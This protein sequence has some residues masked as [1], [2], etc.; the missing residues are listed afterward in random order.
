M[1]IVSDDG[2]IRYDHR[3]TLEKVNGPLTISIVRVR[4]SYTVMFEDSHRVCDFSL[5]G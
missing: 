1:Q 3:R 4:A 5:D 2:V